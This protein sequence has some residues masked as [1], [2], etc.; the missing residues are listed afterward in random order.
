MLRRQVLREMLDFLLVHE[1]GQTFLGYFQ[2][3][4]DGRMDG[5][6]LEHLDVRVKAEQSGCMGARGRGG[7]FVS[8]VVGYPR[9]NTR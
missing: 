9:H 3:I 5:N 8:R 6:D 4:R 7:V 1:V 2:C